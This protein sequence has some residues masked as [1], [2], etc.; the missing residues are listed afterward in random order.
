MSVEWLAAHLSDPELRVFDTTVYLDPAPKGFTIRSGREAYEAGH[1]PGAG[2]LD[3]VADLSDP[4]SELA[5]TRPPPEQVE[6]VLSRSGVSR[7]S[8]VV[9]YS[10]GEVMWA[11]RAWW[12]LRWVGLS[13]A[14]VLDG[15]LARWSAQGHGI[16]Q[17]PNT[18]RPKRFDA[19]EIDGVWATRGEVLAA[20]E[21]GGACM[22][23]ALPRAVHSGAAGLGY[24]RAGHIAGSENVPFSD[25]ID[26]NQGR[27]RA[28]PELRE[29]FDT[30]GALQAKRAICYCGG[31]IAATQNALA[32]VLLEHPSVA[33]YDGGLDEWSRDLELP[34]ETDEPSSNA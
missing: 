20:V 29:H 9:L 19:Q 5:F 10:S 22:L 17:E 23:N 13:S 8:H 32:L 27:F 24:K 31:G 1:V 15:G 33:V 28:L 21:N 11:T 7:E 2:F 14:S 16:S 12:L 18:Y 30:T 4:E 25:L 3:I 6:A 26:S 34:M